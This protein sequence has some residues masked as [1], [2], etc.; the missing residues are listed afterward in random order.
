MDMELYDISSQPGTFGFSAVA[1]DD[2]PEEEYTIVDIVED[3]SPSTEGSRTGMKKMKENIVEACR[4]HPRSE[5]IILRTVGFGSS[6]KELHGYKPL[7]EISDDEYKKESSIGGSTALYDATLNSICSCVNYAEML[8]N[9][10]DI[11]SNGIIF[12]ITDGMDNTS[13]NSP[14]A[15]LNKVREVR[16]SE[17][18]ESIKIILIGIKDPG[19]SGTYQN[20]V[21]RALSEFQ[22]EA[23]LD[24]F[25][26]AGD[27]TP[28]RLAKLADFVSQS[29]SS[30]SQALGS[31]GPS[32]N[33]TF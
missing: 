31:G 28:Q 11:A 33:L 15:V 19:L 12:I 26:D 23:E 7:T 5:K 30:Q 10:A 25:V 29:I 9:S 14:A 18:L 2:L 1:P 3:L 20:T 22:A 16:A 4:K 27:A 24:Q 13:V 8:D 32:Q 6:I 17:K 21:T